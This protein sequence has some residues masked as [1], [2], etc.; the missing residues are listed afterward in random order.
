MEKSFYILETVLNFCKP[1]YSFFSSGFRPC[2]ERLSGQ[3]C[4]FSSSDSSLSSS[5]N[6]QNIRE[7]SSQIIV[8]KIQNS[9]LFIIGI[10]LFCS[11][12]G[13][14]DRPNPRYTT[15]PEEKALSAQESSID[16]VYFRYPYRIKVRGRVAVVMDLHNSEYFFHAFRY[17]EWT[18]IT[19]F[20]R[21][22]EA[23]DDML[24]AETFQFVSLDSIW[25]LD[26]NKMQ[27]TRWTVSPEKHSASRVET[28][29]LDKGLIRSLYFYAAD[30]CFFI[31]GYMG[32]CR[33]WQVDYDGNPVRSVGEIPTEDNR[34]TE[35]R[36]ALAQC[37]RSFL[38]FNPRNGV[39][40]LVTQLGE[41]V[42]VYNRKENTHFVLYGP[43]GEPKFRATKGGHGIPAM[44]GIKGF[45][46]VVVTD[47]YVYAP[48][49]GL[50]IRDQHLAS[51][52]GGRPE[53]GCRSIYVFDLQGN[54]VRKYTLDKPVKGIDVDEEKG[55]I[56]ATCV[57][58]DHPVLEIKM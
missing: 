48:F 54:P 31:P 45:S 14:S 37:W 53:D 5:E 25:A 30:S 26:A 58:T 20:G 49:Q 21:R 50:K 23:P 42:E 11:C 52:K 47:R 22:G 1:C 34:D 36:T 6:K 38:D 18:L 2:F 15:F 13:T 8:R 43:N 39:L 29:A 24:S 9:F 33:Y 41:V 4:F 55:V 10:S 27:L 44:D 17:P 46:D 19:S 51:E 35:P 56:F 32:D 12:A 40:A 16:S 28:I 57:D 7:K 3:F